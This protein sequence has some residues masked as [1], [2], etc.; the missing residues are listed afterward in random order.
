MGFGIDDLS[1][2]Q[3]SDSTTII[4]NLA[5]PVAEATAGA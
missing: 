5:P 2:A 4:G 1:E 3:V